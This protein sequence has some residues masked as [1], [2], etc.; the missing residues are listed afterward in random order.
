MNRLVRAGAALL[1][2]SVLFLGLASAARA[3]VV[4]LKNGDRISGKVAAMV[5]GKLT[6][7]TSYAGKIVIA[8]DQVASLSTDAPIKV[9]LAD[10]RLA[11]GLAQA[12]AGALRLSGDKGLRAP[13]GEV[14][15]INPPDAKRLKVKGQ[16]NLG[17]D[18]RAGNTD[19]RRYDA[20]GRVTMRWDIHRLRV[21]GELH[22]EENK[23]KD[24]VDN[25]LAYLEYNRFVSE[26][27]YAFGNLG[28][29]RDVFKGLSSRYAFG[30]GMGY[31]IWQSDITNLSLELGPNYVLEDT[32][33][34]GERD[35][36]AARWALNFDYWLWLERLQLYHYH[37][38]FSR[39]DA[40][41][42]TFLT[43][44][45]GLTMP[46]AA[47]LAASVEYSWDYDNDPEPGKKE[48]DSRLLFKLGYHW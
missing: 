28:Y 32:E 45:T 38:V 34:R 43:T 2:A 23:G 39:V 21:G 35:Y 20:D 36:V 19:K 30:A 13:L 41:E 37:E 40:A 33:R 12:D 47:G 27:W 4:I 8:W 26:R 6:L 3:D 29:S 7:E 31:Q 18:I 22:R 11:G 16:V 44:R 17:S 10:D 1:M 5:D 14:K 15:A 9:K 48:E 25:D 42:E 46:I 24:T